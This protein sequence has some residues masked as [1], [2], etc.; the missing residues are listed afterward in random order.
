MK[1]ITLLLFLMLA[2]ISMLGQ[3]S[4]SGTLSY[5]TAPENSWE[6]IDVD[7]K[8]GIQ[9]STSAGG[10]SFL[11]VAYDKKV[12]SIKIR[13]REIPASQIPA[14][15]L[16]KLKNSMRLSGVS[17][18]LYVNRNF[19]KRMTDNTTIGWA[20]LQGLANGEGYKQAVRDEGYKLFNNGALS[21]KNVEIDVSYMMDSDYQTTIEK[22]ITGGGM[23]AGK[24]QGRTSNDKVTELGLT[25]PSGSSSTNESSSTETTSGIPSLESQYAKLGIPAN[26]P[27]YSKSELTTQLVTQGVGLVAGIL[28]ELGEERR[29]KEAYEAQ[30]REEQN[31]IAAQI[32]QQKEQK[33]KLQT[34]YI[35]SIKDVKLPLS[36]SN[37]EEDIIYYFAFSA[38]RSALETTTPK[39]SLCDVFPVAKYNDGTWPYTANI[40]KELS[41]VLKSADVV[42]NGYYKSKSEADAD[43]LIFKQALEKLEFTITSFTYKG[44]AKESIS[45]DDNWNDDTSKKTKKSTNETDD[46][47]ENSSHGVKKINKKSVTKQVKATPVKVKTDDFWNN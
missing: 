40:K 39:I 43:Y 13:Q 32:R 16:G 2:Q 42:L 22:E 15:V 12:N 31:Q 17:F 18:D 47:W 37:I 35:T 7:I 1:K 46:F 45:T 33:I 36:S 3:V 21:I 6:G 25:I 41:T 29:R 20:E 8:L 4:F 19:V 26:T 44:K 9:G 23:S 27:T 10:V 38:D 30:K 11:S 28:T 5:R 24:S 34:N 14:N